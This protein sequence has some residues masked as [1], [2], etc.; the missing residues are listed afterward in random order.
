MPQLRADQLDQH[1]A[2]HLLPLYVIHGD[3]PLLSLEV[4]DAIRMKARAA[5]CAERDIF[6]AERGFEWARLNH[7]AADMSLFSDR[8][9]IELRIPNGKPGDAGAEAITT[10][11]SHLVEEN[12][13]LVNLPRLSKTDQSSKWFTALSERAMVVN[14]FPVERA[15]LGLWIGARLARQKQRADDAALAFM[16]DAV[17]GNLLAAHQEIQKLGLLYPEGSLTIEQIRTAVLDVSRHDVYQLAE[18][19][20][21]GDAV[22]TTKIV[23]SLHGEGE[24]VLRLLW[25]L[26]EEIRALGRIADGLGNGRS[27]QELLRDNRIWGEP[28]QTLIVRAARTVRPAAI[29]AAL[30]HA[31]NIDR[32]AKGIGKGDPWDE[33]LGLALRFCNKIDEAG[34]R[35]LP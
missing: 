2:K 3:E 34:L 29:E 23:Q 31:A 20:L 27:A 18:A 11:C 19:M 13:T 4:A 32:L 14:V 24:Q 26:S 1:L 7:A 8:K 6:V 22:R 16:A 5:G 30:S 28:R 15:R 25:V 17:E 12:V 21:A 9:L 10:Y 33:L 35:A